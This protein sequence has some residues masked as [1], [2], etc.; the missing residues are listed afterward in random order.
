MNCDRQ[1]CKNKARWQ[2]GWRAWARGYP[3][4]STPIERYLSLA[5]CDDHKAET[6][7][8]DLMTPEAVART[9]NELL[10]RGYAPLNLEAAEPV[11]HEIIDGKLYMPNAQ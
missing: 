8:E 7:I 9:N 1:E 10:R 5:V 11:F 6:K 2:L 4:T 3:K